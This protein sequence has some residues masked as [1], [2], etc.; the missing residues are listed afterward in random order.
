MLLFAAGICVTLHGIV[1][2]CVF[3]SSKCKN[4]FIVHPCSLSFAASLREITHFIRLPFLVSWEISGQSV[5]RENKL[6]LQIPLKGFRLV[7]Q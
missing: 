6:S 2:L 3:A 1:T 5:L 7:L 4:L